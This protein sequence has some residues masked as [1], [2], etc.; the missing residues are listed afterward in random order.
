[1][2]ALEVLVINTKRDR[3]VYDNNDPKVNSRS[4]DSKRN[5]FIYKE[6]RHCDSKQKENLQNLNERVDVEEE[7]ISSRDLGNAN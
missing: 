2:Y 5:N 7:G 3:K 1:M 4:A 6:I